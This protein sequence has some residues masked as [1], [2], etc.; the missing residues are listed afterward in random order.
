MKQVSSKTKLS[1]VL[2]LIAVMTFGGFKIYGE[3]VAE[4]S[5]VQ[6]EEKAVN[7]NLVDAGVGNALTAISESNRVKKTNEAENSQE[8]IKFMEWVKV[9]NPTEEAMKAV[10]RLLESGADVDVL[11]EVCIFWEDTDE[12][13]S[14]VEQIYSHVPL[15]DLD[16]ID[17]HLLWIEGTYNKLTGREDEA[18]TI[19]EVKAYAEEGISTSDILVANRM[20]RKADNDIKEILNE[21]KAG[22]S[23][24]ELIVATEGSALPENYLEF[25]GNNLLDAKIISEKAGTNL[26]E[27]I[28]A[29][30]TMEEGELLY[31]YKLEKH[32]EATTELVKMGLIP[33]THSR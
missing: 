7:L 1:I 6:S 24:Y 31:N 20:S 29:S 33:E 3:L 10:A 5:E 30:R 2:C 28:I 9:Y 32:E 12:P 25:E 4:K 26:E 15:E 17:N 21:R 18:L 23:W 22:K 13:F 27:L 16:E 14:I 19:E 11:L 8:L